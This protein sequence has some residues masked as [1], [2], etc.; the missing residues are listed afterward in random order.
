MSVGAK[1]KNEAVQIIEVYPSGKPESKR[2][3]K[4]IKHGVDQNMID[5]FNHT[6]LG[7]IIRNHPR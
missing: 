6:F 3:I 7:K 5:A 2:I 4:L 1:P